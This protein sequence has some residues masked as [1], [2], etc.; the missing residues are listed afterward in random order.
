ME[1]PYGAHVLRTSTVRL[2]ESC[3]DGG[4]PVQRPVPAA[5]N[6]CTCTVFM[7]GQQ[8]QANNQKRKASAL[9]ERI[10]LTGRLSTGNGRQKQL[11]RVIQRVPQLA[12]LNRLLT[13]TSAILVGWPC[14]HNC[15]TSQPRSSP[16]PAV[17]ERVPDLQEMS[18]SLGRC[19]IVSLFR[20]T[21]PHPSF[22][23]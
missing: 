13:R 8:K 23:S 6:A 2:S 15:M 12:I 20:D 21:R 10:P 4:S 7:P 3:Q 22:S 5:L 1:R 11:Q 14:W 19:L 18:D 9:A 17:I 16:G